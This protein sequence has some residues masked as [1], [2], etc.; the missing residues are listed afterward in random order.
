MLTNPLETDSV[1]FAPEVTVD[2]TKM[3]DFVPVSRSE[4]TKTDNVDSSKPSYT[5]TYSEGMEANRGSEDGHKQ[6][7]EASRSLKLQES[8]AN[9]LNSE[10]SKPRRTSST[11]SDDV[12]VNSRT[13]K[14]PETGK[15][16]SKMSPDIVSSLNKHL[17]TRR[18]SIKA[19]EAGTPKSTSRVVSYKSNME[20]KSS[21]SRQDPE[22]S[23][24][25]RQLSQQL[26][27]EA[28]MQRA[29]FHGGM[30]PSE[31][32]ANWREKEKKAQSQSSEG[33]LLRRTQSLRVPKKSATA[34]ID[35]NFTSKPG[36]IKPA[37]TNYKTSAATTGSTSST[38]TNTTPT[39]HHSTSAKPETLGSSYH[40]EGPDTNKV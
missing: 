25:L 40:S 30:K 22:S 24:S 33:H 35:T 37:P 18:S 6:E 36:N 7:V 17:E 2:V 12:F 21:K 10:D 3:E 32:L 1:L 11:L 19:S 39:S 38:V 9:T 5:A 15:I 13:A 31:R 34:T 14:A 27:V 4:A 16:T 28:V 20:S 23:P 26:A 8:F 29:A